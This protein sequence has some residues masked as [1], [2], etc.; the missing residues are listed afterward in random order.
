MLCDESIVVDIYLVKGS[1]VGLTGLGASLRWIF[2][3]EYH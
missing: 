1:C 3:W 2:I